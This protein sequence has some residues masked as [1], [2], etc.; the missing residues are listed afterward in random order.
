MFICQ[1]RKD[2]SFLGGIIYKNI[3]FNY[4]GRTEEKVCINY[5]MNYLL[6]DTSLLS[7]GYYLVHHPSNTSLLLYNVSLFRQ[8]LFAF[9]FL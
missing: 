2:Q 5:L 4:L 9:R 7:R 1:G 6:D 3:F 8:N